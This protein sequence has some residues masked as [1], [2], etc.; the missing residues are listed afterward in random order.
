MQLI[1]FTNRVHFYAHKIIG[2]MS[3][4]FSITQSFSQLYQGTPIGMFTSLFYRVLAVNAQL[5]GYF[6][7][8]ISIDLLLC[9]FQSSLVHELFLGLFL[10]KMRLNQFTAIGIMGFLKVSS[11]RTS[12]RC[13]SCLLDSKGLTN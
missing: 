7:C 8:F 12:G 11:L 13:N 1:F 10:I 2:F 9:V 3:V 4:L 5:A 6:L